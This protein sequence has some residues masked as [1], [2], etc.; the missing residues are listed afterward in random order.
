MAG[1]KHG[2]VKGPPAGANGA[3]TADQ[4][5]TLA[6]TRRDVLSRETLLSTPI[7]EPEALMDERLGPVGSSLDSVG[8]VDTGL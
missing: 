6:A 5:V 1:C 8:A 2:S 3:R 4:W 7:R